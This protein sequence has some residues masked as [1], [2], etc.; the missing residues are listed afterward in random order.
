[1][2]STREGLGS[3]EADL[4]LKRKRESRDNVER[5]NRSG[6]PL[7]SPGGKNIGSR[8]ELG[9]QEASISADLQALP[10][11]GQTA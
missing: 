6:G 5:Q 1:V 8:A 10:V 3:H 2:E 9:A 7:A 4:V 11:D